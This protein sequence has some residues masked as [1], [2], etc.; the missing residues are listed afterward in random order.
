MYLSKNDILGRSGKWD[1][2][3]GRIGEPGTI[4][5]RVRR[6]REDFEVLGKWVFTSLRRENRRERVLRK[7]K[8]SHKRERDENEM[9]I[10]G[11]KEKQCRNILSFNLKPLVCLVLFLVRL[12]CNWSLE[13]DKGRDWRVCWL[14]RRDVDLDWPF[15]VDDFWPQLH[16]YFWPFR[17]W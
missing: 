16:P 14:G 1:C 10:D 11:L 3:R 2:G 5:L 15:C 8:W 13:E 7:R 6:F 12:C 9:M 4:E 17:G